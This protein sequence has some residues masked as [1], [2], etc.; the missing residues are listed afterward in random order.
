MLPLSGVHGNEDRVIALA[1]L[2]GPPRRTRASV[3]R[4]VFRAAPGGHG[5]AI[6]RP[7]M[8]VYPN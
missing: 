7:T 8:I 1:P 3:Q 6:G 4:A 2:P 5:R